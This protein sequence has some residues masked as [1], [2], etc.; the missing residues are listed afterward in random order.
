MSNAEMNHLAR[1]AREGSLDRLDPKE[2]S[3]VTLRLGWDRPGGEYRSQSEVGAILGWTQAYVSQL[4]ARARDALAR[5]AAARPATDLWHSNPDTVWSVGAW[6]VHEFRLTEPSEIIY[7]F[8]KP[9]KWDDEYTEYLA[10]MEAEKVR[11]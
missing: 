6:L 4:E 9:H 7:F 8:E 1:L 10:A 2:R 5:R 3:V 11:A